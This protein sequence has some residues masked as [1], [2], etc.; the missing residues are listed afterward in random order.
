[1]FGALLAKGGQDVTFIARGAHLEAMRTTG[2]KV[3]SQAAGDFTLAK[4][5]ATDQPAGI[6]PVDLVLFATKA[7]DLE[8]AART[9]LPILRPDSLVLPLLNGVDIADRLAAVVGAERVLGGMCQVSSAIKAP[10]Q[11]RQ[12]GSIRSKIVFGELAG[13]ITPRA[14]AVADALTAGGITVELSAAIQVD[15]WMKY[16][17]I[18]AV[19]GMCALTR[20]T[21]GPVLKEADTRAMFIGCM[22]EVD[23]LAR[24]KGVPLPA[25][26]VQETLAFV[27]KLSAEAKPSLLL[28]LEQGN[29]LELDALN[30]TAVRLGKELGI[31]TPINQFIT[32]A[33]KLHAAG[34]K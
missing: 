4:V 24:R 22:Q 26:A 20:C 9:L 23:A 8:S 2:L 6:G 27:D 21:L 15:V 19:G 14:Q 3:E 34:R 5:S 12:A 18:D 7:Y 25:T 17:F 33:L 11:I 29:P 10:G 1:L 32:A 31:P 28:S 30:G 13:G 16:M